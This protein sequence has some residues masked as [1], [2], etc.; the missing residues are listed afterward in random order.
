MGMLGLMTLRLVLNPSS[1]PSYLFIYRWKTLH[2]NKILLLGQLN[3]V[4]IFLQFSYSNLAIKK[5]SSP[6][7]LN[8]TVRSF[9]L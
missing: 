8:I 7:N 9:A 6:S 2:Y 1:Y 3:P 5:T 4:A